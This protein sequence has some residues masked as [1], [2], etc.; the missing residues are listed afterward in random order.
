MRWRGVDRSRATAPTA[1]RYQEFKPCVREHCHRTC[2]YC[3]I[4][5]AV[6]GGHRSFAVEHHKPKSIASNLETAIA[7]LLYACN[8]CNSFKGDVWP[9]EPLHDNSAV[10]FPHPEH[11]DYNSLF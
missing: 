1:T 5:E 11:I 2:V 3:A 10:A 9:G 6:L 7:N 8:I 4:G